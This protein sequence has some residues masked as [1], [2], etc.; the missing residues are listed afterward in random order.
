MEN[1]T[2]KLF[3]AVELPILTVSESNKHEHWHVSSKRHTTQ[4]WAVKAAFN[5]LTIP[6]PCIVKLSRI[7][8]R[9][10]D[11]DNLS[12]SFKWI[13]DQ[14]AECIIVPHCTD[15]IKRAGNYDNDPRITWQYAQEKGKPQRIRIEIFAC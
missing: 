13:R 7:S 15:P 5:N 6:L 11:D 9:L 4:K 10:L 12:T 1:M 14:I 8:P 2:G 3:H